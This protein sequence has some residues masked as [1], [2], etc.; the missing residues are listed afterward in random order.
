MS[1][2]SEFWSAVAPRYD[3]VVDA[4]IGP[5]M[6]ERVRAR[7][8]QEEKLGR[9][10]ELGCGTGFFTRALAERAESVVAT[11]LSPGMVEVARSAVRAPHVR[12]QCE[13]CEET[14][15]ADASFDTAFVSLVLHFTR[16]EVAAHEL[17]RI[18]RPGGTLVVANLGAREL[19]GSARLRAQ[20][21][22]L[23]Q[24]VTGYRRRPPPGLGRNVLRA[25]ELRALLERSGFAV[26]ELVTLLDPSRAS[27]IPID[28][29]RAQRKA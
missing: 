1:E 25:E 27:A 6:R 14:S 13:D 18:L 21:R 2:A 28:Y 11:D 9:V 19:R 3:R 4:Q 8:E 15:F 10:V 7:L 23:F 5:G 29:V 16:P 22:I 26:T 17:A 20:V 24:G 12:F